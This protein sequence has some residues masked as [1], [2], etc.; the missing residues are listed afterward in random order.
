MTQQGQRIPNIISDG[1]AILE[2]PLI[3]D[4]GPDPAPQCTNS[5]CSSPR[6]K[7][8]WVD[9]LLPGSSTF[10]PGRLSEWGLGLEEWLVSDCCADTV[11]SRKNVDDFLRI[12][13]RLKPTSFDEERIC[14]G[15]TKTCLWVRLHCMLPLHRKNNSRRKK[16]DCTV[17][18]N[19]T[20][21]TSIQQ[22]H[23]KSIYS[24]SRPV[25]CRPIL[26][27]FRSSANDSFTKIAS[28]WVWCFSQAKIFAM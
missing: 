7:A 9:L 19:V 13:S 2:S 25:L 3:F 8:C 10:S 27:V 1:S 4:W 14:Y 23:C 15:L 5:T 6:L 11:L 17:P 20:V 26:H 21:F 28:T 18:R 24:T 22:A 16:E 12:K